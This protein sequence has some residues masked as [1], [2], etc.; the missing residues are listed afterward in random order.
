[1]S[2]NA[3]ILKFALIPAWESTN[4]KL[5]VWARFFHVNS[6]KIVRQVWSQHEYVP[7]EYV[8]EHERACGDNTKVSCTIQTL[9]DHCERVVR[10]IRTQ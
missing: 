9:Q 10:T 3:E 8:N 7:I 2:T 5:I 6:K 1:M 4:E